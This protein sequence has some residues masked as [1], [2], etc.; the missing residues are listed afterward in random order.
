MGDFLAS[1][2]SKS[3]Q[4]WFALVLIVLGT[5]QTNMDA[6]TSAIG[7]DNVGWFTSAIGVV[8]YVLRVITKKPMADKAKLMSSE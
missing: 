1:V 2:G 7:S 8:V 4:A 3:R 6:V 5:L